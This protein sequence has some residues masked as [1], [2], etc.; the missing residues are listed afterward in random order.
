MTLLQ[1]FQLSFQKF[2]FSFDI[3]FTKVI[4]NDRELDADFIGVYF[5]T[6]PKESKQIL[7]FT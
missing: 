1:R 3:R 5:I 7:A 2:L 4:S 6:I